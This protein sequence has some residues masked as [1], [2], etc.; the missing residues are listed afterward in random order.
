M[1]S[2]PQDLANKHNFLQTILNTN[3]AFFKKNKAIF[4]THNIQI[5]Q[6]P[7][8]YA[9]LVQDSTAFYN[10]LQ[11]Y[12]TLCS[13][14]QRFGTFCHLHKCT[15]QNF[16]QHSANNFATHV[17]NTSRQNAHLHNTYT[18]LANISNTLQHL[19]ILYN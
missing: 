14:L 12:A 10:T 7:K 2:F 8:N 3:L 9:K 11:H 4:T 19:Q 16:I 17:Q 15:L 18:K 5:V 6:T 1:F 13:T